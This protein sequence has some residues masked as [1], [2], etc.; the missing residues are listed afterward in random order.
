MVFLFQISKTHNL[1]NLSFKYAHN[2]NIFTKQH[3]LKLSIIVI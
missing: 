1:L 2:K 3:I